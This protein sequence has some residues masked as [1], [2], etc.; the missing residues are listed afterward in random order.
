ML[1]IA[2]LLSYVWR[3]HRS[4]LQVTIIHGNSTSPPLLMAPNSSGA[5]SNC[6]YSSSQSNDDGIVY[7]PWISRGVIFVVAVIAGAHFVFN[8]VYFTRIG[9]PVP[10]A[11]SDLESGSSSEIHTDQATANGGTIIPVNGGIGV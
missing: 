7:L 3:I 5:S 11:S 1:F 6:T 8:A 10:D 4:V 9:L 2:L